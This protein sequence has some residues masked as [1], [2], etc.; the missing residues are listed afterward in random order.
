MRSRSGH[1]PLKKDRPEL[2][3]LPLEQMFKMRMI[4]LAAIVF[5]KTVHI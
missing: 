5:G 2:R 3:L 4:R 1:A